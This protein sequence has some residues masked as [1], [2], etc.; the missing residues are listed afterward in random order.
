[1]EEKIKVKCYHCDYEWECKSKAL[2]V[3]CPNCIKKTVR[4]IKK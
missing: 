3:T 4:V 2:M 1:M